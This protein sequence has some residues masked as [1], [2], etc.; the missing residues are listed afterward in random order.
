MV[1]ET[2]QNLSTYDMVWA[3]FL[4]QKQSASH[5]TMQRCVDEFIFFFSCQESFR[6][7]VDFTLGVSKL[8]LGM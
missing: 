5:S 6:A 4:A 1:Y 2:P 7:R 3:L 8:T